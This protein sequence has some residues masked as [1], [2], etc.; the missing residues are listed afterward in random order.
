M[1]ACADIDLDRNV[2]LA[3]AFLSAEL[4]ERLV[5]NMLRLQFFCLSSLFVQVQAAPNK[6]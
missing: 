2:P 4:R 1:L 3:P 5:A 6:P